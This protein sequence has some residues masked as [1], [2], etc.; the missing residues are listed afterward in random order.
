[1][2]LPLTIELSPSRGVLASVLAVHAAAALTLF[3]VPLAMQM[4]TAVPDEGHG[5]V[6][7]V[8]WGLLVVSLLRGV[9]AELGKRGTALRLFEDG[10][11]EVSTAEGR[12]L[13][14]R[15]G[16][17]A[18]DLGWALWLHLRVEPGAEEASACED[19]ALPPRQGRG[20]VRG[21]RVMLLR[22]NLPGAQ[23]RWL[24]IWLRHTALRS[25]AGG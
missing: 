8:A 9:R 24:R 12:A 7:A 4:P 6:A 23:W 16:V 17:D 11:V 19:R 5:A 10:V 18:V 14:C 21:R 1:M 22:A 3:H 13:L 20:L 2:H 25:E 15:L